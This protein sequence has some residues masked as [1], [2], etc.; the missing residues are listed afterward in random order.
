MSLPV[1]A[2]TME[3]VSHH[4]RHT[5]YRVRGGGG[6]DA[7]ASALLVH[8]SGG[9]HAVWKAQLAR[10]AGDDRRV[11]A[12][13]LSGHGESED[14]A[15]DAGRETLDAYARDVLAVADAVDAD[16]LVGNSL[17]GAVVL[18]AVLDHG[19]T[20]GAVAL[21]GSGAK[22]AVLDDLRDWLAGEGGGFDRAV[23]FL[24]GDDLL[25][26]D[27]DDRELAFSKTAMRE[28]GR[29]VVERDFLSCHAFDVR[30][31]LGELGTPVFA[32][33]GEH[34]RL[35]P[36]EFHEY[37][38]EHVQDGAWTTVADAAHL[39]MLEAPERFNDDLRGF[40]DGPGVAR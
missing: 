40:L 18:T 15:T 16:A 25:F 4:G 38:A 3:T 20:P 11:A 24:H 10:L 30:D 36:P 13:D 12:L 7:D 31:R 19:A 32:L 29:A 39:S 35:T 14:V 23:E 17:G 26:H 37:V 22:L 21:A 1:L 27:P 2:A 9:T 6:R 5:A 28:C 8:G 33:T 34:D